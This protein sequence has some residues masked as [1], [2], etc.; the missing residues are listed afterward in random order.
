MQNFWGKRIKFSLTNTN[1]LMC[2]FLFVLFLFPHQLHR[3]S[4]SVCWLHFQ[5]VVVP[6]HRP[7]SICSGVDCSAPR[8]RVRPRRRCP[9]L[10][11]QNSAR[12]RKKNTE[13]VSRYFTSVT[14]YLNPSVFS[15]PVPQIPLP[16]WGCSWEP[17]RSSSHFQC[18][19]APR[20]WSRSYRPGLRWHRSDHRE[21]PGLYP[22]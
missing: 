5:P 12:K 17:R 9:P 4:R 7:P 10:H 2:F 8:W 20:H 11:T 21:S 18:H 22:S 1:F 19:I 14:I 16:L 13:A 15:P 6:S 3:G